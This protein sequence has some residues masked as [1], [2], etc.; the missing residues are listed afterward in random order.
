MSASDV[1]QLQ[2]PLERG[3]IRTV[4][5]FNGRLLSSKDLM[6]EQTARRE[7]DWRLGLALGDG[8]ALGLEVEIDT[9]HN[10]DDAPVVKV[11]AGLA[12]N[13][14]GQ[15]LR[16]VGGA[17][18]ALTRRFD[19][20]GASCLFTECQP[21]AGGTY[22]R[23]AG[24]YVLTIAPAELTEGKA[25]TNGLD[26][27]NVRCNTDATVEAVQFRLIKVNQLRYADLDPADPQYRNRLAYRF[28]GIEPREQSYAD[29]WRDD[30]ETYG[31]LDTLRGE[32]LSD[33]D[34]P[35]ALVYWTSDG[36]QFIDTWAVRR[37]LLAP[38]G[39]AAF[40]FV[41]RRRRLVEA[42]AMCAQFQAHLADLL[43]SAATP[44]TVA[45][46]THFRWLPPFG[47]VPLQRPPLRGFFE[48]SFFSG[49]VRPPRPDSG[50][51][52]PFI[53]ARRLGTLQEV[54]L[55]AT[56]TDLSRNEFVWVYRPWQNVKA[57]VDGQTVQPMVVFAS[58]L[59]PNLA[60]ARFDMA[61]WEYGNYAS[62]VV[63]PSLL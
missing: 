50:Q 38:D 63:G 13:R 47:M 58:G 19:A 6:R 44:G 52:T 24:V 49:I 25:P 9:T 16:L 33:H 59:L 36:I 22:V 3:G 57:N 30:P 27:A 32:G 41:A 26:P 31:L 34:V 23:G 45:A 1:M 2:Q 61:R 21:I 56:A 42:H 11:A 17:S 8:V 54:A 35:L 29:P 62:A 37:A 40:S 20:I 51:G 48:P 43:A 10:T 39:L 60:V 53:D 28:F 5:F 15:S 7:S 4:N 55:T 14:R 12:I 18:V 46:A